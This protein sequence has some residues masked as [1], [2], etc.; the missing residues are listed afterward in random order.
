MGPDDREHLDPDDPA[1]APSAGRAAERADLAVVDPRYAGGVAPGEPYTGHGPNRWTGGG[2]SLA[3]AIRRGWWL[4]LL[5]AIVLLA[6]AIYVGVERKPTYTAQAQLNVGSLDVQTQALPGFV[7]AASSLASSYSRVATSDRLLGQVAKQT[8]QSLSSLRGRVTATP[9]SGDPIVT[10]A[11]AAPS[12]AEARRVAT[13]A[14]NDLVAYVQAI[15]QPSQSTA[16]LLSRYRTASS[17][18]LQLQDRVRQLRARRPTVPASVLNQAQTKADTAQLQTSSLSQLYTQAVQNGQGAAS[19]RVLKSATTSSSDRRSVLQRLA[20]IGFF[21]GLV[22]GIALAAL[23]ETRR[24]RGR[25]EAAATAAA[26]ALLEARRGRR[27]LA[28][29]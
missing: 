27:R 6:G 4:V 28:A 15:Q 29:P 25:R 14:T 5:P 7:Q 18:A 12:D 1:N 11:A 3:R 22:I 26:A 17:T 20:F 9:L 23:L 24:D 10:L 13:A 19:I 16:M 2:F 8:G 21:G